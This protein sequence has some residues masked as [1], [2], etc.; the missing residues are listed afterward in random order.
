MGEELLRH[1]HAN[2]ADTALRVQAH[3]GHGATLFHQGDFTAA[4]T[5]LEAARR[6]YDPAEHATHARRV[7]RLR[8]RCGLLHVGRL[9][10]RAAG[11][12]REAAALDRE[13]L[14][15]ARRL[16]D[17]FTLA[18]AC[19]GAGVTRQMLGDLPASEAL[20][21]EG[22][23]LAEEHGFPHVLGIA[24]INRGWAMM[25]QGHAAIGIPMLR[26]GVAAVEATGAALMHSAYLGMLAAADAMEGDRAAALRCFDQGLA[27]AQISGERLNLA[28]LLIGKSHLLMR[29]G[30]GGGRRAQRWKRRR[31]ACGARSRWRA[32][33]VRAS[34]SCAA[35]VALAR[36]CDRQ[37]REAEGRAVLSAAHALVRG[38]E[39][40]RP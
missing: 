18:W 31:S 7:R 17:A 30:T 35:A 2:A 40:G 16:P 38:P 21:A 29:G 22:A 39:R 28:G 6:D 9:G 15:L 32:G 34:S 24:T 10:P 36:H 3:Y 11:P 27:E 19:Y 14:A 25:M 33:K 12:G 5:H 20:S 37:G 26:E 8:S 23:T 1:A 13:G 4:A